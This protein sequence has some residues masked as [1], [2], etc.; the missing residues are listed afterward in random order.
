MVYYNCSIWF[1]DISLKCSDNVVLHA[2]KNILASR[3]EVFND[4]IF[5]KSKTTPNQ[6]LEF[7][8]INSIAMKLIL[9]Y[10]YTSRNE[11][12][13]LEFD[14]IIEVYYSSIYFSA[15]GFRPLADPAVIHLQDLSGSSPAFEKLRAHTLL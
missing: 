3:S 14:K 13:I 6:Q 15:P 7:D 9:E 11:K 1:Y 2:S 8:K 12:E 5:D 10:L 4:H